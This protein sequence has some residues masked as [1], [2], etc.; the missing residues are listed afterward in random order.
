M[1]ILNNIH[2]AYGHIMALRGIDIEV[3]KGEIVCLIGSNG[4]GKTTT[5]MTI[6]GIIKPLKGNIIFDGESIKDMPAHR[7]VEKG[8]CHVPEG[9]RIFQR[10]TVLENLEMGA[11]LKSKKNSSEF[12]NRIEKI[13]TLFPILKE[14]KNQVGGTLSGGEQQ[15]LA[16]GRALMSD[17]RLILLDE[18][19]L[20][21]S[22]IMASKIFKTIKEINDSGITVLLVE[23]NAK[24]ALRLSQR[25]YILENGKIKLHGKSDLLLQNEDVKKAYLGE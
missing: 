11:F 22:P 4:A 1:L 23:Q 16:I 24:A 6:S 15:M 10:L 8:I 12:K 3:N 5:L 2:S 25:G 18:P 7:I 13:F 17:P 20:G 14:R 19:S 9:R 21:L